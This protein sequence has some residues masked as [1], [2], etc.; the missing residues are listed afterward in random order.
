MTIKD[1]KKQLLDDFK[2]IYEEREASNIADMLLEK[3]TG[4]S[5]T[6]SFLRKDELLNNEQVALL[7]KWTKD[8][9]MHRPVQYVLG[10]AWFMGNPFFVSE[11]VL[12]PRP[13]TEELV[14]WI[15]ETMKG[16]SGKVLDI[17]TGSGCIAIS[18]AKYNQ[19]LQVSA[20]DK[21]L[22]ALKIAQINSEKLSANVTYLQQDILSVN[23]AIFP[24]KIDVIVSN[25]PYIKNEEKADMHQNVLGF[26]PEMALFVP[27]ADPL[28]F[29]RKIAE[30]AT[31]SLVSGGFLFFEI[32]EQFG[33]EVVS[34]LQ[35]FGFKDVLLKKDL[36]G[37][38]RMVK[39]LWHVN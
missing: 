35:E 37:K 25:P 32:N 13:E 24:E 4:Y 1:G 38:D 27:D 28:L 11:G 15:L 3:L 9:L 12:I 8:L 31:R 26:E 10:E 18:L 36:Q 22:D 21:S 34:L 30:I 23:G 20:V 29:Y 17:G 39:A 19:A 33:K 7:S 2:E 5:R 16:K 6:E 14:D